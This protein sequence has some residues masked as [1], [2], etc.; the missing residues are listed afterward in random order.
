MNRAATGRWGL[1]NR[2][3][4]PAYL[5]A[6]QF[7]ALTNTPHWN[8]AMFMFPGAHECAPYG[9]LRSAINRAATRWWFIDSAVNPRTFS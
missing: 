4:I 9:L 7:I 3:L 2:S 5:V 1:L 6:A 8:H